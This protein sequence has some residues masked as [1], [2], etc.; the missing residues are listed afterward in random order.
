MEVYLG[1]VHKRTSASK[2]GRF[3]VVSGCIFAEGL[4]AA[5]LLISNNIKQ[6]YIKGESEE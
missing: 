2:C 1:F 4:F 5:R 6:K 3:F